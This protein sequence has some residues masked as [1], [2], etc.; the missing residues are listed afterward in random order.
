M[1]HGL[2]E[3]EALVLLPEDAREFAAGDVVTLWPE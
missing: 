3:T 2:A 1:L